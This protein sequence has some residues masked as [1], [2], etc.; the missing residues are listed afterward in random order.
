VHAV[1]VTNCLG[2]HISSGADML[3]S[4][5]AVVMIVHVWSNSRTALF[6]LSPV[7]IKCLLNRLD[8]YSAI[9]AGLLLCAQEE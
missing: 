1:I 4:T 7:Q 6:V 2:A 9:I 3:V 8:L 5:H